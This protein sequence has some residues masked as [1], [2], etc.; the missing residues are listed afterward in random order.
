MLTRIIFRKV[1]CA[2]TIFG[3]Y[4][5]LKIPSLS[6]LHVKTLWTN[7]VEWRVNN[8]GL[9]YIKFLLSKMKF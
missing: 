3:K 4:R 5:Q 8:L 9:T 2:K 7:Q 1:K 6:K